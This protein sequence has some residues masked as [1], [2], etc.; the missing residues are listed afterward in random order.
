MIATKAT[1]IAIRTFFAANASRRA[2]NA[3]P[4][5]INIQEGNLTAIARWLTKF[6][7]SYALILVI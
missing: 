4:S 1:K 6:I 5:L 7:I 3:L 2:I